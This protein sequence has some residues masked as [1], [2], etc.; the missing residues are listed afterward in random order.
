LKREPVLVVHGGAW[1]IPDEEVKDH[2]DGITLAVQT[3]WA[4]LMQGKSALDV[5]EETVVLL[6]DDPTFDAGKG[7]ILN[8]DG[9]V[10]MDASI[11]DGRRLDAGGVGALRNFPNPIRIARRVL[12]KTDHILLVGEGCEAFARKE[13]FQSVPIEELLTSRELERLQKLIKDHTFE[14]PHAFG[15]KRG[16]VG[17]VALDSDGNLAAAT[18]TGGTPKKIPGRVG[19]T[20][21]I[22]CGTYAENEIGAV[23]CTGWGESI[24]KVMLARE[25][26]ERMRAKHGA[27]NAAEWSIDLLAR[28]VNGLGGVICIDAGGRLGIEYNS[29]RMARGYM[30]EGMKK[31]EVAV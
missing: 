10:E 30:Q 26:A 23:S 27:Q 19:D 7:S 20:P 22:G 24:M 18:S 4:M 16:T 8:I 13:G 1:D 28:R 29:P 14:T 31:P 15:A 3:G 12:E 5:V 2:Q 25:V 17:A 9:S 11:M 6:E 21:I